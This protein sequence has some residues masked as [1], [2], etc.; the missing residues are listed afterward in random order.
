[1]D[2]EK[3]QGRGFDWLGCLSQKRLEYAA[4]DP[5]ATLD[6]YL[7]MEN[8]YNELATIKKWLKLSRSMPRFALLTQRIIQGLPEISTSP[9]F[10]SQTSLPSDQF[11]FEGQALVVVDEVNEDDNVD[12]EEFIVVDEI[13]DEDEPILSLPA[14]VAVPPP[15]LAQ[16]GEGLQRQRAAMQREIRNAAFVFRFRFGRPCRNLQV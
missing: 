7:A 11:V 10:D 13:N 1:M 8:F 14:K 9:V 6:T 5:L 16:V 2:K 12:D 3:L 4:I 15:A